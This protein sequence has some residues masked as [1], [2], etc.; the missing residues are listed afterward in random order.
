[1]AP[2]ARLLRTAFVGHR[3]AW[4][5]PGV[6]GKQVSTTDEAVPEN[7]LAGTIPTEIGQLAE[8][9]ELGLT[10][11]QLTGKHFFA[12]IARLVYEYTNEGFVTENA[13]AG[14]I[15]TEIGQ[16]AQLT[17][18]QLWR[19]QLTGACPKTRLIA[20]WYTSVPQT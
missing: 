19:N 13:L 7:A 2:K 8:L 18:L 17:N 1:M 20:K 12:H 11:N 15:P 6:I 9:R 3:A 14:A 4:C 16:L 10:S 5:L